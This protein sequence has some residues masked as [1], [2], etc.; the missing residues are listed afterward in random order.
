MEWERLAGQLLGL[1]VPLTTHR[2]IRASGIVK[3]TVGIPSL[4]AALPEIGGWTTAAVTH[5]ILAN[6]WTERDTVCVTVASLNACRL[7]SIGH[8]N[9]IIQLCVYVYFFHSC[10]P[11]VSNIYISLHSLNFVYVK[12]VDGK[13]KNN[14]KGRKKNLK[15]AE[16]E[17]QKS[18]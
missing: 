12:S 14:K 11:I 1:P 9:L 17:K 3:D 4:P 10:T 7:L 2:L 5:A 13:C 8:K 16:D 18:K 15:G 6:V